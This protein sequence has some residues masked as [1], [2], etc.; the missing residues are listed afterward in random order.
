MEVKLSS[1]L[2]S[3]LLDHFI[4]CFVATI[5]FIPIFIISFFLKRYFNIDTINL[6]FILTVIIYLNKDILR[7]K[8]PAKRKL[9]FQVISIKTG[10]PASKAQCLIR[11]L[12]I[13]IWPIEVIITLFSK[14]RRL[15]DFIAGS[16]VINSNKE[17]PSNIL[18]ELKLL[19]TRK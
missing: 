3:M 12:F 18:K 8:S 11:N 10:L 1:R 17:N 9:G 2:G 14:D 13:T 19:L 15:G 5:V 6:A 7:G 4:M 16:K